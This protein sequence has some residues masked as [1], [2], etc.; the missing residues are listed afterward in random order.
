MAGEILLIII[1]EEQF[2]FL[3]VLECINVLDTKRTEYNYFEDGSISTVI[4]K[5]FF[6]ENRIGGSPIFK[7]PETNKY[8]I[9]CF[10]GLSD[11]WDEFKGRYE[12]LNLKGLEFVEIYDSEKVKK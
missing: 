3:N 9:L 2:Y 7:I 5:Y 1:N 10:E 12:E 11:P 6:H 8:Q 4:N